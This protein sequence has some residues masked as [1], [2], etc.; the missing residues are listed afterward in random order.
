MAN[1]TEVMTEFNLFSDIWKL[2]KSFYDVSTDE[3]YWDNLLEKAHEIERK[4]DSE[5]CN[6]LLVAVI[7]EL[8]RKHSEHNIKMDA[9]IKEKAIE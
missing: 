9:L 3:A 4:Y 8:E 1:N 2:F 5:F 6:N 7:M